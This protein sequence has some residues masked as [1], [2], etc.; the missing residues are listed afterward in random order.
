MTA[1][2]TVHAVTN[3]VTPLPGGSVGCFWPM[4]ARSHG[5]RTTSHNPPCL[6]GAREAERSEAADDAEALHADDRL[7]LAA[8]IGPQQ[9]QHLVARHHDLLR[10]GGAEVAVHRGLD[11]PALLQRQ[12]V[13]KHR[14]AVVT[15]AVSP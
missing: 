9:L 13:Q 10:L 6:V 1:G 7:H 8:L 12:V 2:S 3:R 4:C 5:H 15:K 14:G 11:A